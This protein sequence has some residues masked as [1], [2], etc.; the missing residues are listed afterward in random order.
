SAEKT[1]HG[2]AVSALLVMG[3]LATFA[4]SPVYSGGPDPATVLLL[5]GPGEGP[6]RQIVLVTPEL[7]KRLDELGRG[8]MSAPAGAV[9][10]SAHYQAK[11]QGDVADINVDLE[12]YSFADKANLTIPLDGVDLVEGAFLDGRPVFPMALPG[13]QA[14]YSLSVQKKGPHS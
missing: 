5:D 12:V 13:P 2:G 10:T 9:L 3:F 14:G 4:E 8:G 6:Q 1:L 11:V 7:M